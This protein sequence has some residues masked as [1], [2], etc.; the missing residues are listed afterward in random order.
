MLVLCAAIQ[1]RGCVSSWQLGLTTV[2]SYT[3]CIQGYSLALMKHALIDRPLQHIKSSL[4]V[5]KNEWYIGLVYPCHQLLHASKLWCCVVVQDCASAPIKM[6][7]T[8]FSAE[9]SSGP[10]P[11]RK[12][13]SCGSRNSSGACYARSA[14]INPS[15]TF[16]HETRK[17]TPW[18]I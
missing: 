16:S 9:S 15:C 8:Y 2:K 11:A 10:T 12:V 5:R 4:K 1:N 18:S 17:K 14:I 3:T 13:F 7:A 6:H